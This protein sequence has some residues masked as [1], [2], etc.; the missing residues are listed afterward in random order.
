MSFPGKVSLA[1]SVAALLFPIAAGALGRGYISWEES[2]DHLALMYDHVLLDFVWI[3]P[4]V[5]RP[6][7]KSLHT[8]RGV[9]LTRPYPVVGDINADHPTMHPG[10]WLAFGDLN[11]ADFWR[12]K[13]KVAQEGWAELPKFPGGI[14]SFTA[15]NYYRCG[16]TIIANETASY[17]IETTPEG[18]LLRWESRF[19]PAEADLTFGDQEEMGLGVRVAAPLTVEFGNGVIRNSEGG[20]NEAGTWGKQADWCSY[21]GVVDGRRVGIVIMPHPDN[22]RRS[23]FHNR[24][25]GLMVA[26]P[27]GRKAMTGGE[28]S[29]VVVK[30]GDSL[31][32]RFGIL[33][34]DVPVDDVQA[35]ARAYAQYIKK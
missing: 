34:L 20:L 26:N 10:L 6:Y 28:E 29:K 17:K 11:G 23:W 24:D 13:A 33:L 32:L 31:A 21:S 9:P 18:R 4:E 35:E 27:F 30:K 25:Y 5:K 8:M 12:N 7:F 3:D 16:T 2:S 14:G 19:E 1:L 15:L 22:F